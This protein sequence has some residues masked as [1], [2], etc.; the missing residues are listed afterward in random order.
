[1]FELG[2]YDV[3]RELIF[4]DGAVL[5]LVKF[6][7]GNT[8]YWPHAIISMANR[9]AFEPKSFGPW[10]KEWIDRSLRHHDIKMLLELFTA[11]EEHKAKEENS[12][13]FPNS[14][15]AQEAKEL[16][17]QA[18]NN[19]E[20]ADIEKVFDCAKNGSSLDL[21]AMH[22]SIK[23]SRIVLG[24]NAFEMMEK[25]KDFEKALSSPV[26]FKLRVGLTPS[27]SD[28]DRNNLREILDNKHFSPSALEEE[29]LSMLEG[30]RNLFEVLNETWKYE[31]E[32]ITFEENSGSTYEKIIGS[33]EQV[34]PELLPLVLQ[35]KKN[36][37]EQIAYHS[38]FQ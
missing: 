27:V 16:L 21:N 18:L 10:C 37:K 24:E 20:F 15:G 6:C 30:F 1:M 34:L 3:A 2:F 13:Q 17:G 25:P 4:Q 19:V 7:E 33:L 22:L 9:A 8:Q 35:L 14:D 32:V 11:I 38:M 12:R 23:A 26:D 36:E 29:K 5:E 28:D 31:K